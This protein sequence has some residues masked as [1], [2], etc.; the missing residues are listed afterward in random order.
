VILKVRAITRWKRS[1]KNRRISSRIQW[2]SNLHIFFI[3][4]LVADLIQ[5]LGSMFDLKWVIVAGV[6]EGPFCTAQGVLKHIGDTGVALT[7]MAIAFQTF[8]VIVFRWKV[9][10]SPRAALGVVGAIWLSLALAVGIASSK[11]DSFYGST[12]YWCWIRT[13]PYRNL[14]IALQYFWMWLAAALTFVLY[15]ISWAV[16]RYRSRKATVD[17]DASDRDS[18]I[19]MLWYPVIYTI[20]VLPISVTRFIQFID[21]RS[22]PFAATTFAGVI[23]GSSGIFNVLLFAFTRPALLSLPIINEDEDDMEASKTVG[24]D[25]GLVDAQQVTRSEWSPVTDSTRRTES[26]EDLWHIDVAQGDQQG[27]LPD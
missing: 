4:L 10:H 26:Q 1:K 2:P 13:P 14:S 27:S 9:A 16:F 17:E 7:T 20:T 19:Q 6:V 11:H 15:G 3:S 23:F 25:D 5:A 24:F 18:A 12:R 8:F 22:P 21:L